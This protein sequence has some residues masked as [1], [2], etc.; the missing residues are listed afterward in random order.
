MKG[1]RRAPI[2]VTLNAMR[3]YLTLT[4]FLAI[5]LAAAPPAAVAQTIQQLTSFTG[6]DRE[7]AASPDGRFLAY[8]SDRDTDRANE[9]RLIDLVNGTDQLLFDLLPVFGPPAWMPDGGQLIV[10]AKAPDGPSLLHAIDLRTGALSPPLFPAVAPSADQLMADVS[11]SGEWL[12][13]AIAN[14]RNGS[15]LD[16]FLG[17][18]KTGDVTQITSDAGNEL[19]PRFTADD[20]GLLFFSRRDTGGVDDDIYHIDLTTRNITRLTD[21]EDHD[22]VPSPSPDGRFI[23]F[24]SRRDGYPSLYIMRSDG[25]GQRGQPVPD[26]RISH[27]AWSPDGKRLFFTA[28]PIEGGPA[29]IMVFTLP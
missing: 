18:L 21:A 16:L 26:K 27:P 1:G 4:V 25:T 10:S 14:E 24:A 28:R 15:D 22:F 23:A 13:F 5:A 11:S 29:D 9:L 2:W 12:A 8:L 7:P 3:T 19:W 6:E 17:N 20:T